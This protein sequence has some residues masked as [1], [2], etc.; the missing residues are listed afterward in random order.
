LQWVVPG[1]QQAKAAAPD[2]PS[3]DTPYK[4]GDV[5]LRYARSSEGR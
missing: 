3:F 2:I 1:E 5:M 4:S